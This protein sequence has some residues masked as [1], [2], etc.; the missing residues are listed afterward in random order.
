MAYMLSEGLALMSDTSLGWASRG[1]GLSPT[2]PIV[3]YVTVTSFSPRAKVIFKVSPHARIGLF[4]Y[5]KSITQMCWG[6]CAT[7]QKYRKENQINS[8][9][10]TQ[11]LLTIARGRNYKLVCFLPNGFPSLS[12]PK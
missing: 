9:K 11:H 3:G 10:L 1:Q 12:L 4:L 7:I 6:T 8:K 5:I 2:P